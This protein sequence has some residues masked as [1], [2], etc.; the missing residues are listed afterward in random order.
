MQKLT[1]RCGNNLRKKK[2]SILKV[3][4]CLCFQMPELF[5]PVSYMHKCQLLEGSSIVLSAT[6]T[7]CTDCE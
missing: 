7:E 5:D 4:H 6:E 1:H 2:N 3:M